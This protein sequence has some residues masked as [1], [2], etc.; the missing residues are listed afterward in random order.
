MNQK[1]VQPVEVYQ[2]S[3]DIP[4]NTK[5]GESDIKKVVLP[6]SA[7]DGKTF[8]RSSKD[9]IGKYVDT[10]VFENENVL[11]K[12]LVIEGEIDPFESMDLSKYRKISFPI[13]YVD[14]LGG[15]LKHGDKVDL[16]YTATGSKSTGGS[17]KDFQYS[18]AFLQNIPVYSVT[19]EDGTPYLDKTQETTQ[20]TSTGGK[21][22]STGGDSAK[23]STITLAVTLDQAEEIST[24]LKSGTIRI[25]GRFEESKDC[26]SSGFV[27]GEYEK[28]SSHYGL[29][30][31]NK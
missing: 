21:D 25:V 6:A 2:Y 31:I 16:I 5:I 29:A 14:G 17:E 13:T 1:Q 27:I 8:A 28:I 4:V 3:R 10:K 7:V 11:N 18:R 24:R 12:Q 23:M 15:N 9:I 26:E 19:T 30:E 20:N 22:I